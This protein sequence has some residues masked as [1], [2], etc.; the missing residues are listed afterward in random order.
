MS[1]TSTD[2]PGKIIEEYTLPDPGYKER[3]NRI[4]LVQF[5][6]TSRPVFLDLLP[7]ARVGDYV[8]NHVRFATEIVS[9]D[10][11]RR[12]YD[13]LEKRGRLQNIEL[14]LEAAEAAPDATRRQKQR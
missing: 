6:D 12:E 4:G 7:G 13:E 14:D 11:A 3:S 5:G 8:R 9:P 10:E 1:K 2:P